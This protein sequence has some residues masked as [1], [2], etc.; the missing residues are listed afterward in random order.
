MVLLDSYCVLCNLHH[1]I[2]IHSM[3]LSVEDCFELGRISYNSGDFYHTMLWMQEALEEKLLKELK[4]EERREREKEEAGEEYD[5]V[6]QQGGDD[7]KVKMLDFL[8]FSQFKVRIRTSVI[9]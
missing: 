7:Q 4:E 3:A 8:A 2:T 9:V 6:L 1:E 5:W